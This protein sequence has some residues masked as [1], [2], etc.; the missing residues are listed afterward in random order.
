ML[1]QFLSLLAT[2]GMQGTKL[3]AILTMPAVQVGQSLDA[4]EEP[5]IASRDTVESEQ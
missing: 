2:L 4:L 3:N 5:K 1:N